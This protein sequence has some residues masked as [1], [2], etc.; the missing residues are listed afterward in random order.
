MGSIMSK[1]AFI[2]G[3]NEYENPKYS[4]KGCIADVNQIHHTLGL[5]GYGV[6]TCINDQATKEGI[7][8]GLR[9][10]IRVSKEGD[11]I[12]FFYSGHGTQIV[13]RGKGVDEVDNVFE[14]LCPYDID[15]REENYIL[16]KELMA[17][18]NQLPPGT[19][20][21]VILD[22]CYSGSAVRDL[23]T[24]AP[25]SEYIRVRGIIPNIDYQDLVQ[26]ILNRMLDKKNMK[27]GMKEDINYI[28]WA[29][30]QADQRASEK[31]IEGIGIRGIFTYYFCT[32]IAKNLKINRKEL[33]I[34]LT[35]L[36]RNISREQIPLLQYYEDHHL[37][38]RVFI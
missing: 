29:A 37:V 26:P 34:R 28:V 25:E 13:R 31:Y 22:C 4:L 30:C 23:E 5:F 19:H 10:L 36:V 32:E 15:F 3:I 16:D 8:S 24:D 35:S 33:D 11:R 18:F 27:L 17:I 12:A 6:E 2:V 7:I 38:D 1:G 14:V 20:L 9:K 21:D